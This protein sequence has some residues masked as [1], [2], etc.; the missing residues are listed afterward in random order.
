MF[1]DCFS[2]CS[3]DVC[4]CVFVCIVFVLFVVFSLFDGFMFSLCVSV[5]LV[6]YLVL[7]YVCVFSACSCMLALLLVIV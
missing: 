5:G 3:Y 6:Y 2:V 7:S 1:V 4:L